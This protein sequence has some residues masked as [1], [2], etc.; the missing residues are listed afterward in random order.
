MQISLWFI[1]FFYLRSRRIFVVVFYFLWDQKILKSFNARKANFIFWIPKKGCKRKSI[2]QTFLFNG[3]IQCV[4]IQSFFKLTIILCQSI[5]EHLTLLI[6]AIQKIEN[7]FLIFK[8]M[9]SHLFDL[10]VFHTKKM[11]LLNVSSRFV[12]KMYIVY[13]RRTKEHFLRRGVA[14]KKRSD[15][16]KHLS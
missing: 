10:I 14:L 13:Y 16:W 12:K 5:W 6:I 8:E 9:K 15:I 11:L 2:N 1:R 4:T 3:V 7:V